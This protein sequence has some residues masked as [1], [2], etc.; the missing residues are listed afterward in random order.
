LRLK[1]KIFALLQLRVVCGCLHRTSAGRRMDSSSGRMAHQWTNPLGTEENQIEQKKAKRR[2]SIYPLVTP[3]CSTTAAHN[4]F[5][6]SARFLLRFP[7]VLNNQMSPL[8]PPLHQQH[9]I[10]FTSAWGES[11]QL[12]G[13]HPRGQRAKRAKSFLERN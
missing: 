12:F 7:R 8:L 10:S 13:T 1:F 2:A 6:S 9:A 4:F 3:N 5:A 11:V